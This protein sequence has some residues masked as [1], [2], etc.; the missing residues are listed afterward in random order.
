M[1]AYNVIFETTE[2]QLQYEVAMEDQE[3][4]SDVMGDFLADLEDQGHRLKGGSSSSIEVIWNGKPLNGDIAL[5]QQGVQPRDTLIVRTAAKI[6]EPVQHVAPPPAV[7]KT[8]TYIF[9]KTAYAVAA[10]LPICAL[11]YLGL[12]R[13]SIGVAILISAIACGVAYGFW[14]LLWKTSSSRL[15]ELIPFVTAL[16][17]LV[18]GLMI[19]QSKTGLTVEVAARPQ[20]ALLTL[21]P[22]AILGFLGFASAF[23]QSRGNCAIGGER[24]SGPRLVC[25]RCQ[26]VCCSRHWVAARVRCTNC[27]DQETPWLS[28]LG[29]SWWDER[30]GPTVRQ[31]MCVSCQSTPQAQNVFQVRRDLRECKKCGNLQC[32]WCWDLNNGRCPKCSWVMED[33][34]A[35]LRGSQAARRGGSMN[36]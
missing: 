26:Q 4:L 9:V 32:R 31:G 29:D 23:E 27:E 3:L 24:F 15:S 6:A 21:I 14:V 10:F 22:A 17:A 16:V 35:S 30:T 11:Q 33:L 7:E 2:G 34:P 13:S 5:S 28:M 1:P 8:E 20:Q 18:T 25:P 36:L 12:H 19:A